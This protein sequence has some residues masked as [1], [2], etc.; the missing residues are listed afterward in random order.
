MENIYDNP[1]NVDKTLSETSHLGMVNKTTALFHQHESLW[2]QSLSEKLRLTPSHHTTI[3]LP[4]KVRLD[5]QGFIFH[6]IPF[7]IHQQSHSSSIKSPKN[8]PLD[9]FIH[10]SGNC[11][12]NINSPLNPIHNP[13]TIHEQ[14]KNS[15]NVN[16]NPFILIGLFWLNHVTNHN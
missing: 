9:E 1:S 5:W 4:K 2:I 14:S 3:T 15:A 7:R 6:E 12:T 8:T 13:S 10:L 11:F 16:H